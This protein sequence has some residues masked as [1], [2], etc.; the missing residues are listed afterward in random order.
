MKSKSGRENESQSRELE[1]TPKTTN[2]EGRAR[3]DCQN[4]KASLGCQ[5]RSVLTESHEN[6]AHKDWID[7]E[8]S[9]HAQVTII[10]EFS[11]YACSGAEVNLMHNLASELSNKKREIREVGIREEEKEYS[12]RRPPFD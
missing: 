9:I 5:N 2:Q 10:S 3:R 6:D 8:C 4:L 12:T 1:K 7:S 11:S